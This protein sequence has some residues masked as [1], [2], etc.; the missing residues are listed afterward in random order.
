MMFRFIFIAALFSIQEKLYAQVDEQS[1][2]EK[3]K[4]LPLLDNKVTVKGYAFDKTIHISKDSLRKGF[5]LKLQDGSYTV[6]GFI[7]GYECEACDIWTEL[8][9][10]CSVTTKNFS[11]LRSLK[12]GETIGIDLMKVQKQGKAFKVP[13]FMIVITE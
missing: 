2:I 1:Y 6:A 8:I 5:E 13:Y 10:G 4:N 11:H 7:L 3:V 9:Y 12:K